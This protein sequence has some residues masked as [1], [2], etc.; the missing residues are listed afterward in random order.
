MARDAV[1][2]TALTTEAVNNT[3]AGTT[4]TPANGANIAGV[5]NTNRLLVR[6]TNTDVAAHNVTFDAGVSPPALRQGIGALVVSVPAS[7]DILVTLESARHVQADGSIN[8][9]FATGLAGK[10]SAIQLPKSS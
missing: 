6:V 9:D 7:G 2:I 1:T 8:V 5:G 4:I 3:P 10:I